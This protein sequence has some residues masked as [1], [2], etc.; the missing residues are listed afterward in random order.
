LLDESARRDAGRGHRSAGI[1]THHQEAGG[2]TTNKVLA[3]RAREIAARAADGSE[4][5]R[6]LGSPAR[7][8]L[9]GSDAHLLAA[10]HRG[11]AGQGHRPAATGTRQ[12]EAGRVNANKAL[13]QRAR[14]MAGCAAVALS[15]TAT[16]TA[17]RMVER[18][19][20]PLPRPGS[21]ASHSDLT[22][23]AT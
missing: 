3:R 6:A 15:T 16:V 12:Q 9:S 4:D 19:C 17:A 23:P 10:R 11:D 18:L 7:R 22:D 8:A 20:L 21:R 14:Q 2:V 5:R 13:A 1:G